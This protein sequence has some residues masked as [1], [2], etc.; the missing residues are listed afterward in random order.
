[1]PMVRLWKILIP[2][3]LFA[4]HNQAYKELSKTCSHDVLNEVSHGGEELPTI[5]AEYM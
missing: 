3:V 1:M 2:I 5:T 4:Q